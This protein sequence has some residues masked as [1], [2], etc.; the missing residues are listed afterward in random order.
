MQTLR[1]RL[2]DNRIL[3][4]DLL[5]GCY[6]RSGLV[7]DVQLY[8][9]F[10]QRYSSDVSRRH[11]W[12][13]GDWQIA[14]WLCPKVPLAKPGRSERNPLS[15]LSRWKIFDNLRRS[16]V[17]ASLLG[18]L[19]LA[20]LVFPTP[21]LGTLVLLGVIAQ[22][23]LLRV[24]VALV[25]PSAD[26]TIG[27]HT[28]TV[29]HAMLQAGSQL[30]FDCACLPYEAYCALDAIVRSVV[31]M[32][33]TRRKLL[34]WR[35][36]DVVESRAGSDTAMLSR[37][38]WFAP[39]WALLSALLLVLL[40]PASLGIGA[41]LLVVWFASPL[42][43]WRVSRTPAPQA[44]ELA[45]DNQSFLRLCA[46]RTWK[47]FETFVN[48]DSNW[49]PPDNFQAVPQPVIAQ[50]TSP[51]NMGLALLANLTASDFGY[52]SHAQL[53][54]RTADAFASM[55]KLDRRQGHFYNWYD[56]RTL[57]VLLP[58]Y[59]ST[60]DSGNLAAHLHTLAQGL[61]DLRDAPALPRRAQEGARD[62]I[63]LLEK[64]A[65]ELKLPSLA[66]LVR[67]GN[68]VEIRRETWSE[69]GNGVS[70]GA[71][72]A[73]LLEAS[74]LAKAV[75]TEVGDRHAPEAIEWCGALIH[76]CDTHGDEI[77]LLAPWAKREL[78][79]HDQ[80]RVA[81][82]ESGLTLRRLADCE[83]SLEQDMSAPLRAAILE[84]AT[85][86]RARLTQ[87]DE[88]AA[89][90]AEFA[91]ADFR[92]LYVPNRRLFSIGYNA[93]D[94]RHDAGVYD[95]LASEARLAT[96]VAITSNQ[97]SQE[98]WFALNRKMVPAGH[99]AT[100]V[101]WSGSMFEYL[102]PL[103]VMP[104]FPD[105]LLYN[106][107][108]AAVQSQIEYGHERGVPWGMSESGYS[109]VDVHHN[110]QYRAF[111]VPEVGLMRGL[112]DD[113][114]I[115]PYA[116][117]LALLVLP[118]EAARNLEDLAE[119][120]FLARYG[121]YEAVDYTPA[122]LGRGESRVVVQSFMAHHQGM[123]L[124]A[125]SHVLLDRPMQRRFASV[126]MFKA[127]MLL[128]QEKPAYTVE[129]I[130]RLDV[131][132][133]THDQSEGGQGRA[134]IFSTAAT[135]QPEVQLLSNGRYHVM[136]TNS[137]SGYSR[138]RDLAVTR[139]REDPT[140]DN[141]G[142][143][144]F[145]RDIANGHYWSSTAQPC[146]DR[147]ESYEVTFT[148]ARVEIR[149]RDG[150]ISTHTEIAVSPEDDVEVRRVK[151][152]N[153]GSQPRLLEVTSYAEV[154]M[155][156]QLADE[157]HPAFGNLFVE[158]KFHRD[159]QSLVC[160]RRPRS[161]TDPTL[162]LFHQLNV[163]GE[164]GNK[165]SFETD[166]A[167]FIGRGRSLA[168]ALAM[169]GEALSESEGSVLD[170]VVAIRRWIKLEPHH[171][172]TLNLIWGCSDSAE[173]ILALVSKY[174]DWNFANR[175]FDLAFTQSQVALRHINASEADA[176]VYASLAGAVI[177]ATPFMR[178]DA[179][180]L[181][182]NT[183]GQSALWPYSISGDL[184]IMLVRIS[185]VVNIDLVREA[186]LAHAWWRLRG[187]PVD[188]VIINED[189]AGY[190]QVLNDRIMGLA[191][192]SVEASLIDR[193]G[194]VF[195]RSIEQMTPADRQLMEAVARLVFTDQ[196]GSFT[197]QWEL[198]A[199][200]KARARPPAL[201]QARLLPGERGA[202]A[203]PPGL[204]FF[205]GLG[206]FSADG[207]EYVI[208]TDTTHTTPAPWVNVIA[209]AG[210]G[211]VLSETG[212]SYSWAVNSQMFRLT[213]WTNDP[214][215]DAGGEA[216]YIRD[217]ESGQFW[218]PMPFPCGSLNAY[219]TRHGFGYSIFEHQCNDIR[220]ETSVFVDHTSAV[221][222][223]VIKLR[224]MS[225][226]QRRLSVYGYVE[227][228]LGDVRSKALAHV[229]TEVD[230]GC[231]ALFARNSFNPDFAD[232][233]GF[234]SVSE[235][236]CSFTADR[237]EFIG[238][239]G[240][241]HAPAALLRERLSNRV[242]AGLD[243]CGAL[244]VSFDISAD[245]ERQLVYVLG[246]A[247]SV[248]EVRALA[249]KTCSAA[250]AAEA[251]SKVSAQWRNTLS[252]IQVATPDRALN[253]L[254]NGW[255]PYQV[256]ACRFHARSGFYQSGGAIG[257]RDQLQD[258]MALVH[259][260][261][262]LVRA[263]LLRCAGRQFPE[264]DVQHWWHPP[265]GRGVRTHC[266]D[267]YL[268]LPYVTAY[269]L[270]CTGDTAVLDESVSFIDAPKLADNVESQYDQPHQMSIALSLYEH[271]VRA[272][273]Y[274]LKFGVHGLPLMGSGDWNDGMN[275]VGHEGKGE[276]VWL[277]FFLY[278]VLMRFGEVARQRGD[279][280][281]TKICQT[282]AARLSKD[283]EAHGWDGD[284]YRRAYFDD[285]QPLGSATNVECQIDSITQS[286]A[287]LSGAV[288]SAHARRAM[289]AVD[290]HLVQRDTALVRL[291]APP[292]DVAP[293]D[294]GYIK[295][296]LPGVRENGGQY[297]H[298]AIWATMA[299]AEMGDTQRAWE[300]FDMINPIHH[301]LDAAAVARYK[302]EPYVVTADLYSEPPHAGRGGWSWYTG[303]AAWMYRLVIE[304]LLGLE[305]QTAALK[306]APRLPESWPGFS[307]D[308]R[309]RNTVY[310]ITL[311][312]STG[313]EGRSIRVDSGVIDGDTIALVD[314]GKSHD[315]ELTLPAAIGVD[316]PPSETSSDRKATA[317]AENVGVSDK[318]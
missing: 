184:A 37:A 161:S 280:Q 295:G 141:H 66:A 20:W 215:S 213:P 126:P 72:R 29:G 27:R 101:S 49:L 131:A 264:G 159:R 32:L 182:A 7:S 318:E 68:D 92:L 257:F 194:G 19:M 60:V 314:D 139:W 138:W 259:S 304:S 249:G 129:S 50:R 70:A 107:S 262:E 89:Q 51:T 109:T 265:L 300:L 273:L 144:C 292:F 82:F 274:G 234:Y 311:R 117:A 3:S 106:C 206:G 188:L 233:L 236:E 64:T 235:T 252:A 132:A 75:R 277:G 9:R 187:L 108:R 283:L 317:V 250:A 308:Y 22:P 44:S 216:Y 46:R 114:V 212:S 143:Y 309:Y 25:R 73:W 164:A 316:R 254:V 163:E 275:R 174:Q 232:R 79:D 30:L 156:P 239:N 17:P 39:A 219:V 90:A 248:A 74:R 134:R 151:L 211:T 307:L 171:T 16:L 200:R 312:Q 227:W 2:P 298:A 186:L 14:R 305:R 306:F 34:E 48:A 104:E 204:Q 192:A 255:L 224:N 100:L 136:L 128:L 113:L 67:H 33:A 208:Q 130:S 242:G 93:S 205:N 266:S 47:F 150:G 97:V 177:F 289:Q 270:G 99:T 115:A 78:A 251:L 85:R 203:A 103:L 218:S 155:Q 6:A 268:W 291:L 158:S 94:H 193:P 247:G 230:A 229:V 207:R 36:S 191:A 243:A 253:L 11:R 152:H 310:R 148:D 140:R 276:S 102:M 149:R 41:P 228:V 201:S 313:D 258:S 122:R 35:P 45:A 24:I 197:E 294:P 135:A 81:A 124:L 220:S 181:A 196:M 147:P 246:A 272:I 21:L 296:Y 210:F 297:T 8:E 123:S 84:G 195:I 222:Y 198:R 271:C 183:R 80:Q 118:A 18:M 71:A 87:L 178:A 175:V 168:N 157:L 61:L 69:G 121:F 52:L 166:R 167:R 290:R 53:L 31:R 154:V 88:L 299:F 76:Q 63:A 116:S 98:S 282:E 162:C 62:A 28:R 269:Y 185:D 281:F 40:R 111:G 237:G 263:H 315:V 137:G 96:F 261:P 225:G 226:Q 240:G 133:G 142:N 112:A 245:S 42:L 180:L 1:G 91:N 284:W 221:K 173:S 244:G 267:D 125:Y 160:T 199:R 170:P 231:G 120:G 110:Y 279:L 65:S 202:L 119:R 59:V 26:S 303:S 241:L 288:G 153:H 95:L 83:S 86:A 260:H 127:G 54:Q 58:L 55:R 13:R 57:Q 293:M 43:A 165:V 23:L 223:V 12:I 302:V 214:V 15:G 190:R 146:G 285:G 4:H 56:T 189:R 287:V 5:E 105:T 209:N 179:T 145:V 176:Q 301:A 172:V 217:D 77:D 169:E 238:R 38:M 10:P 286:W 278:Q 256:L